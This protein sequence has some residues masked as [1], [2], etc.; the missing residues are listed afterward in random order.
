[1]LG[2]LWYYTS[3]QAF[4]YSLFVCFSRVCSAEQELFQTLALNVNKYLRVKVEAG[5]DKNT[6]L[7]MQ[8]YF[9]SEEI[10]LF[11][12]LATNETQTRKGGNYFLFLFLFF[13]FHLKILFFY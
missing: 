9:E 6:M 10:D 2:T 7:G 3:Q 13:F 11:A 4:Y 8:N 1:M 5:V 12:K